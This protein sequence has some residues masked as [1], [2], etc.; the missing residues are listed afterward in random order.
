MEFSIIAT[1]WAHFF[2]IHSKVHSTT[3]VRPPIPTLSQSEAWTSA[4]ANIFSLL[5]NEN[6]PGRKIKKACLMY[7]VPSSSKY[8]CT[9]QKGIITILVMVPQSSQL[10]KGLEAL[11]N[12]AVVS[13]FSLH[14]ALFP[15]FILVL[16]A[17][18]LRSPSE[19]PPLICMYR[20]AACTQQGQRNLIVT[21]VVSAGPKVM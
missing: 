18:A 17:S 3:T 15:H 14:R 5:Q 7:K 10:P 12:L 11:S 8:F 2:N 21:S 13:F 16:L 19:H 9:I 6:G 4:D 20:A 1:S